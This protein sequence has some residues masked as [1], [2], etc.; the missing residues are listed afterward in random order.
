MRP[1]H[2]TALPDGIW[3]LRTAVSPDAGVADEHVVAWLGPG[4]S[5]GRRRRRRGS[6]R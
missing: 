3:A 1:S 5:R 4:A 6:R 2:R